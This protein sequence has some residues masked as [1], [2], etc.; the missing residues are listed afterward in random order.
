MAD[1]SK[2]KSNVWYWT[3]IN[4]GTLALAA[5]VYFFKAP[6]GFATGG[7]SGISIVL[8]PLIPF[9]TQAQ[10]LMIINGLMLLLGFIFLGKGCTLKTIYCSVVYSLEN[11]LL[12]IIFGEMEQPLTDQPFLELVYAILLTGGASAI[13][14]NCGASSGGTDIVALIL[15]KF[16]HINVGRALLVTDFIIASLSFFKFDIPAGIVEF[17][18]KT[19][20][21]SMLGL[22]AKAF[23][24]DGVIEDISKSKY[25]TV[26]TATPQ[27]IATYILNVMKRDYTEFDAQGGYTG[28]PKKVLIMMCNRA[29]A[30]KLKLKV[31]ELDP[32][33]FVI[34]TDANEILGK[35]FRTPE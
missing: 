24:I 15:K 6:N 16:T 34:I 3:K 14:F 25:V 19:G 10:I 1:R 17:T 21:Y 22:F 30:R 23:L 28:N 33:S 32:A 2:V 12:E 20:L 13:L 9:L 29:E 11:Y 8:A 7:V 27:A 4:I 5:G 18:V 26:I 31:K 35:G